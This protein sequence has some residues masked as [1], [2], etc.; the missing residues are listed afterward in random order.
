[1]KN[2][3]TD[4]STQNSRVICQYRNVVIENSITAIICVTDFELEIIIYINKQI[5]IMNIHFEA[6]RH[7]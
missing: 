7:I 3:Q 5:Y 4:V 2:H 6:L 1:M